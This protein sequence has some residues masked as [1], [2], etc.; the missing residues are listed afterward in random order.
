MVDYLVLELGNLPG[1]RERKST[2]K[3]I[4]NQ[5]YKTSEI[6]RKKG[7][8]FTTRLAI[9]TDQ[10]LN[11]CR[12]LSDKLITL[13]NDQNIQHT[14]KSIIYLQEL[15][16][17]KVLL[18]K[19]INL[20][21][22]RIINKEKIPHQEKMFSIFEPHTQWLNKGKL[23]KNVEL[24]LNT[25]IATDEHHFILYHHIMEN[26]VDVQTSVTT[27]MTINERY[28]DIA[29]MT[30]ISFDRNYYSA[31]G[32][33]KIR[34]IFDKVIMPKPGKKTQKQAQEEN[35]PVYRNLRK[36]HSAIEANINQ[37]EHH[38]LH[39]CRDKGIHGF[40]KYVALGVLSYNL[41]RLGKT[42]LKSKR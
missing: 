42:I 38:G 8:D 3:K 36:Q 40:K 12:D 10:Y 24:G 28:K 6:H 27:A 39:I 17:Y 14:P 25:Q 20:S 13:L 30:S 31:L 16:R 18:D 21:H 22:R 9:S 2:R 4:K 33:E 1:W 32:K 7:K 15:A 35:D 41:H 37:L 29:Q 23:H 34:S 11:Q 19:H 5:Y 26:E